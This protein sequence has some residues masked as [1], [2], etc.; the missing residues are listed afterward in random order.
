MI[1]EQIDF[2]QNLKKELMQNKKNFVFSSRNATTDIVILN[3]NQNVELYKIVPYCDRAKVDLWIQKL[4]KIH[5]LA[6][7]KAE[8]ILIYLDEDFNEEKRVKIIL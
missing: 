7:Y 8:Y 1:Q 4:K 5:T 6:W 3:I 2:Y